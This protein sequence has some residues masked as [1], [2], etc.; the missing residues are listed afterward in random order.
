M[1]SSSQ[2][3]FPICSSSSALSMSS[4]TSTKISFGL[5]VTSMRT[6]MWCVSCVSASATAT[7]PPPRTLRPESDDLQRRVVAAGGRELDRDALGDVGE[8]LPGF[9][10]GLQGD[11][12]L[13]GVGAFAEVGHERNLAEQRD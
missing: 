4:A 11:Q 3:V 13:A 1:L 5:W 9:A 2:T 7:L 8:D 10:V 12:G 6:S